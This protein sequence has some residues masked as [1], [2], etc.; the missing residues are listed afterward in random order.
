MLPEEK[1]T[2]GSNA[3][4]FDILSSREKGKEGKKDCF[5]RGTWRRGKEEKRKKK[6]TQKKKS[7]KINRLF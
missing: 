4:Y 5:N 2:C 3:M 1:G 6:K 7:K